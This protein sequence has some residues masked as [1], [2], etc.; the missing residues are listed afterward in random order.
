MPITGYVMVVAGGDPLTYFGLAVVPRLVPRNRA[1]SDLA[2]TAH[3]S[4]Q[5]VVYALVTIHAAAALHH[6]FWRHNDVLSR[7]LPSL[8]RRA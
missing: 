3:L 7:M 8:R 4:L 6:H 1:L 2:D 5:Y